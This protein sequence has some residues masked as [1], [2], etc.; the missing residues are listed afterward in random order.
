VR[1][2]PVLLT[3]TTASLAVLPIALGFGAGSELQQPM[4]VVLIG[5]LVT[6]TVLTVLVLP[7]LLHLQLRR[8]G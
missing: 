1:L 8:R 2:R 5:G 4:A 3:A 6:S 7:V